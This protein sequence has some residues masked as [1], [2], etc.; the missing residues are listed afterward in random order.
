MRLS[1]ALLIPLLVGLVSWSWA[2]TTS[3]Q[4]Y[5]T[6]EKPIAKTEPVVSLTYQGK[7][8]QQWI[9]QLADEDTYR[10][11]AAIEALQ[12][13]GKPAVP[14][15]ISA[16]QDE[17]VRIRRG[18]VVVLGKIG[19]ITPDVIPAL[20]AALRDGDQQVR[21]NAREALTQLGIE[22]E[23]P[24][25]EERPRGEELRKLWMLPE[26]SQLANL[27]RFGEEMFVRAGP[28]AA[29]PPSN[30]PVP[31]GY[32]LGP[33]DELIIRCW[34]EGIEHLNTTALVSVEGN[35]YVPLLGEIP[36]AGESL[37]AIRSLLTQQ[38]Q[39]FYKNSQVSVT[40]TT[41][42]VVTVY[43]TGDVK[44]PGRYD[45]DGTA[46]VLTALYAAGGPTI[47]GSLRNIRWI[48]RDQ[49]AI[50]VDL[51]PYLLQGEPLGDQ[52]L[53]PGDT[54]FVGPIGPEIGIT[55]Q[56]RRPGRYELTEAIACVEAVAL[57]GGLAPSA[58]TQSVQVWRVAEYQQ[59]TVINVNLQLPSSTAQIAGADFTLQAG[60]VVVIPSVLPI[61]EN[62]ARITG[63][64][65]RPG[66]YEVEDSMHLSD[67]IRK[68]QGV[69]EGAYLEQAEIRR[70]DANKQYRY[71]SF[72][73]ADVLEGNP[74]ED[75]AVKSYDEVH[76]YY[77]EEVVPAR[78]VHISGFIQFPGSYEYEDGM[79]ISDL[80]FAAHGL[81]P[82]ASHIEYAR[83]RQSGKP[84]VQQLELAWTRED[85]VT[86]EP[87]LILK[88]DDRVTVVGVGD[89]RQQAEVVTVE[90]Q[91]ARPGAYILRSS[92]EESETVYDLLHR[93]GPL[94]PDANVDGII[95]Y[96]P[97]EKALAISQRQNIEQIMRMYNRER[98][99]AH[100]EEE[101]EW[102]ET[103]VGEQAVTQVVEI[104][105]EEGATTLVLPPRRLSLADWITGIPVE[106]R[107]L[108]DSQGREG[109]TPLRDGDV[110]TV[111]RLKSTVTVLG[112]VIRPGTALYRPHKRTND[113]I[114]EVGGLA[115]DA[116]MQR[117]VVIRTNSAAYL[118]ADI[119][120]I[121]PGDIILIPSDY[122]VRT[123]RT[124]S[125]FERIL[126]ALGP[127]VGALLL[128]G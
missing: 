112:A 95:V 100:I 36:V 128:A 104:L 97:T 7:A 10:Q 126:R 43:V 42:R 94:L 6:T 119:K 67:L 51:Y 82:G 63:A 5:E 76:I 12:A 39:G 90:G 116:A 71:S 111:P 114:S 47:S 86:I 16:L 91:V 102:Q 14:T 115:D 62:A 103:V 25:E 20:Q 19:A 59:Q 122:D 84:E 50:Q 74:E 45:L 4:Q 54:I 32:L 56:V 46:T 11:E 55:G 34:G 75:I 66:I 28:E 44:R 3:T 81:R 18:A 93:A 110:V 127:I 57:A 78:Q 101:T 21:D 33:G 22:P 30:M 68:A 99:E 125:G 107:K 52:P 61:P 23:E 70:L 40:V 87:D 109:D 27:P 72:S 98:V 73:V 15:L 69:D 35:I 106:G 53:R 37:G 17:D 24:P 124:R 38:L 108:L 89:F 77:R 83:G 113:Y 96:R 31:P 41:T 48:S 123:I 9:E 121:K 65:R 26:D 64:V 85:Q 80:I 105:A 117:A 1:R 92:S 2:E 49:E 79:K 60:D 8:L 29:R 118:A 120:Q 58:Y 13:L 88:P